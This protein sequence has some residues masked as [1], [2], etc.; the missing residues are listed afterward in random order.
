MVVSLHAGNSFAHIIMVL[1]AVQSLFC[2]F[3][4]LVAGNKVI[5]YSIKYLHLSFFNCF[6]W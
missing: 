4:P 2:M 1:V 5:Y 6:T 3:A